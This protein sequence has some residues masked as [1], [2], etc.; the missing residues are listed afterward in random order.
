MGDESVE[1]L[2]NKIDF[3]AFWRHS[4]PLPPTHE[5]ML[6]FELFYCK[7]KYLLVGASGIL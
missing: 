6:I 5:T 1:T 7:K 2:D 4:P 3:G